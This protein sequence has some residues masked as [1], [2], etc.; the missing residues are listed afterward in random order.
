M[1]VAFVRPQTLDEAFSELSDDESHVLAGGQSLVLLMNAGLLFASKLVSLSRIPGLR[2]VRAADGC[3]HLGAMCTHAELASHPLV[4]AHL[5]VAVGVFDSIGNVRVRA[6]GT[7]GGNIAH[8][9]PAQDP[10]VLLAA[11]G[12]EA[13]IAGPGGARSVA[14]GDISDSPFVT[15]LEPTE[16]L[17]SVTVPIPGP[18]ARCSYVKFLPGTQ[19]DY[20]T[21]S[22]C[23]CVDVD[24]AGK[25]TDARLTAGA[26]GGAVV[27]LHD[28]AAA[29]RGRS[30]DDDEALEAVGQAVRE[31]VS[32]FPDRRG[33]PDYK[34]HLAGVIAVRAL[35]GCRP[36]P[37]GITA[38]DDPRQTEVR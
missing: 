6:A 26:I 31:A 12:A 37:A 34:R 3:L 5:P 30:L 36:P 18:A 13:V 17:T 27:K 7:L 19:D 35:T 33:S 2:T 10:P 23:A 4:R 25:V 22:M 8:A 21:V 15:V 28:Q 1:S 24:E 29:L 9:D 32:P 11:M 38:R 20:A 16:I 14:V